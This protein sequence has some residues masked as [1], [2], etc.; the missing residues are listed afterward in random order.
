[1]SDL[2]KIA[3]AVDGDDWFVTRV[4]IAC[5]LQSVTYTR[6]VALRVAQACASAITLD[7]FQTVDTTGVSDDQI[8]AAVQAY[9]APTAPGGTS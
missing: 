8:T 9:V 5:D 2:L 1:M 7:Q 6:D 4:R 3:R